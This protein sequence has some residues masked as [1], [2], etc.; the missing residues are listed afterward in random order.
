MVARVSKLVCVRVCV[1]ERQMVRDR[2]STRVTERSALIAPTCTPAE[3]PDN[4]LTTDCGLP[5]ALDGAVI[6]FCIIAYHFALI[7]A[8]HLSFGSIRDSWARERE[9]ERETLGLGRELFIGTQFSNL[10]T[11]VY[12]PTR[13]RMRP[14]MCSLNRMRPLAG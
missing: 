1:R 13:G 6:V 5:G 7:V 2:E 3:R 14:L 8:Y 9:R 11:S 12:P 4:Y 10:Y